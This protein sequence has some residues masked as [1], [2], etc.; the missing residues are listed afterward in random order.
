MW[1]EG[2]R[3]P[4]SHVW[5]WMMAVSSSLHIVSHGVGPQGPYMVAGMLGV[6]KPQCLGAY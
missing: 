1:A 3:G 6:R 2:L 4:P 5:V